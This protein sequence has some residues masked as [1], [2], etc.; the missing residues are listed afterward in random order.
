MNFVRRSTPSLAFL[1][2]ARPAFRPAGQPQYVEYAGDIHDS[3]QLLLSL[4]ND[5][6]D[7]SKIEAG[8]RDLAEQIIDIEQIARSVSRLVAARAKAGKIR[9]T[10]TV[11]PDMPCLRA[12]ERAIKQS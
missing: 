11:P 3:G 9:L 4:I 2:F 1:N 10:L 6:L 8:K 5:I 7:M 12:E